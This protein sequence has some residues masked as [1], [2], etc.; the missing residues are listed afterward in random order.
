MATGFADVLT[1]NL[2]FNSQDDGGKYSLD[3]RCNKQAESVS[4]VSGLGL[5]TNLRRF[6]AGR[7]E[8]GGSLDVSGLEHLSG[9]RGPV[10]LR[11]W[12]GNP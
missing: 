4:G 12:V 5:L 1:V 7:T 3:S 9:S 8:L 6:L 2:G 10:N 11:G